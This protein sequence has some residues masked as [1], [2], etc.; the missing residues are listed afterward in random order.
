MDMRPNRNNWQLWYAWFPSN[1]RTMG[2]IGWNL[3]GGVNRIGGRS[4]TSCG[5]SGGPGTKRAR[6]QA[7]R[8]ECDGDYH[9]PM[10]TRVSRHS[11][12]ASS[13]L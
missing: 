9:K 12:P 4:P 10:A 2:S 11:W 7:A 13:S 3:F 8:F 1:L 5:H 6:R